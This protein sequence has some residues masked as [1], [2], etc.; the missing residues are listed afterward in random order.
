M[1]VCTKKKPKQIEENSATVKAM[2][3]KY[4]VVRIII[5]TIIIVVLSGLYLVYA[6][7]RYKDE[8]SSQAIAL[9]N[10]IEAVM[11]LRHISKLSG[12]VEDLDNPEY[13]MIKH[14]LMQLVEAT[15]PIYFAYLMA[16]R[17]E[18][19]VILMDSESQESPNYSPPGQIYEEV[20]DIY[21]EPFKT[22]ETLFTK[23]ITDRWGNWIS[24]LVPVKDT[25]TG[26]V[27]AVFGIDYSVT[28]WY[29]QICKHMIPDII[30]II[31]II[32]LS[33]TLLYGWIQYDKNKFLN[34]KLSISEAFYRS[35]F[36]K[37]PVGIAIVD[38]DG[39]IPQY[40]FEDISINSMFEHII[41]RT[42][43]DLIN[44]NWMNIT[45][46][47][48]LQADL[49]NF[50]Q[51]KKG[52]ING[53]SMEKRYLRPDGSSIWVN[54]IISTF[55]DTPN[56]DSNY[57]CIIQDISESKEMVN[58]IEEMDRKQSILLSHLPGLAY[59][60]KY[61]RDGTMLVVSE[62]CY[63]LT[64]YLPENFINNRDLSFNDLITTE[65]REQLLR[66][67]ERTIPNSL[68]YNCEYEIKTA[69]G[70]RKWVLEMGRGIYDSNGQVEALE[71]IILDISDRKEMENKLR[72]INDHDR[73]TGLFNR[74]YLESLL[75][76]DNRQRK[77]SKRALI[78][79]NL[80][81]VLH[82][83]VNYGFH[84][85]QNLIKKVVD[86]LK[87]Y[88]SDEH[89]LFK[90]Y[91]N[92]FTFYLKNYK[93]KNELIEF[94]ESIAN[95]LKA[96][97]VSERVG[98]GIGIIEIDQDNELEIDLLLRRL[99]IASERSITEFDEDFIAYF[100]NEDLEKTI[101]REGEIRQELYKISTDDDCGGLFLEYQ[102]I[103]DLRTDSICG[104]EALARL[105]TEKL[106]LVSPVEFIP[107]AE[108]TK[109]IIPIGEKIIFKAFRFL[110]KL[111]E[112][113]YERINISIN[114]SVAQLFKPDFA[115]NLFNIIREMNV[116]PHNIG[117]EITE[118]MFATDYDYINN[119]ISELKDSGI[120]IAIDD[121]GI[122]YSSLAREKELNVNC[123]KIDKYFIDKLL[124]ADA[125]KAITGD[126]I[127]MAHRMGH[128][129]IAEGVEKEEQKQYLMAHGCDKIQGY[130]V[131]RP[132][133]EGAAIELLAKQV[134]FDY[135]C[136]LDYKQ[137]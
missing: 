100:Y 57:I 77:I 65:H 82:L 52:E 46:P 6:W 127:S 132:L 137:C 49:D 72:Y 70:E 44:T 12:S 59:R 98:G 106:G 86:I 97:L 117:I 133:D 84:Y 76:K 81:T 29:E 51:F 69:A 87:A 119:T 68:P 50:E 9:A 40:N 1:I 78:V 56:R 118:S 16:E 135:S 67:W 61:D 89:M 93:D 11:P 134:S 95:D 23:S 94:S 91:E 64:G 20:N 17:A 120:I 25:T 111:K 121:F 33:F 41:G 60:C 35:V 8:A 110:N 101:K 104:F 19:I 136:H 13:E 47:E 21:R 63:K 3:S 108:K 34:K 32:M 24:V 128:C 116:S 112:L 90:T 39:V 55:L 62:G 54:M 26:N 85:T 79:V 37:A 38:N 114:I 53:Y 130:L 99:L 14:N 122:G 22:G 123:L 48:D 28:E 126:I 92:R 124:D 107:I 10:S 105:K 73:W 96:L 5:F 103:L 27:I 80:S 75:E 36:E 66:E 7:N 2:K 131:G 15:N 31:C 18:N 88:D 42:R 113:G 83:T 43:A 45:H 58:Q 74:D 4:I 30:I 129:V 109:L 115:G 125:E 71:G 102:P